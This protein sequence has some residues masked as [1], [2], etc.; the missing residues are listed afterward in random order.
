V[1][2]ST[3]YRGGIRKLKIDVGDK[4]NVEAPL[5]AIVESGF[6]ENGRRRIGK[7]NQTI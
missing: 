7:Q 6:M 4:G 1:G 2:N 5:L 3:I